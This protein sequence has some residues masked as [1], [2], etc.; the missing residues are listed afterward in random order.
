MDTGNYIQPMMMYQ[1]AEPYYMHHGLSLS[2]DEELQEVPSSPLSPEYQYEYYPVSPSHI[3]TYEDYPLSPPYW[4]SPISPSSY[5]PSDDNDPP[6]SRIFVVCGKSITENILLKNFSTYGKI[7]SCKVVYDK[8]TSES[9]GVAFIKYD[10]AS[11]AALAFESMHG[12]SVLEGTAPLKVMIAEKRNQPQQQRPPKTN[13]YTEPED[14]PPRSRLFVVCAKDM[15]E[16]ELAAHFSSYPDM[17]YCKLVKDRMGDKKGCAFVKFNRASIAALAMES[18]NDQNIAKNGV[19]L[20]V[21]IADPKGKGKRTSEPKNEVIM[22]PQVMTPV[23][24][25]Y[26]MVM[27]E[28]MTAY[29][30]PYMQPVYP[31]VMPRQQ[32]LFVTFHKS[33]TE[34]QFVELFSGFQCI[35]FFDYKKSKTGEPKGFGFITFSSTQAALFAMQHMDGYEFPKGHT[36]K[37]IIAEPKSAEQSPQIPPTSPT[38]SDKSARSVD[39]SRLFVGLTGK[40]I[41][42]RILYDIFN[43]ISGLENVKFK[44]NNN[45]AFVK[46][47]SIAQA[48][49]AVAQFDG[50]EIQGIKLRVQVAGHQ[51]NVDPH[52]KRQKTTEEQ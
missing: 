6:F 25:P 22:P 33:V 45:Y 13:N 29:P 49:L 10:K 9:R 11:A 36:L 43:Q 31:Y 52:R 16:P 28:Y 12:V 35:E 4:T 2:S 3:I 44:Q 7:E 50:S 15:T 39:G 46:Y 26:P 14:I 5:A 20:K 21:L 34:D 24:Y 19:R 47:N 40:S 51:S 8:T 41:T 1:P 37:V 48:Q 18:V 38:H 42:E 30:I 17:V 32:R 23:Y 27:P